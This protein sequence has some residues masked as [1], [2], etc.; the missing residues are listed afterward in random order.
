M[1]SN[2]K[3]IPLTIAISA[4]L[5]SPAVLPENT[6]WIPAAEAAQS[7]SQSG[8]SEQQQVN[9]FDNSQ[10]NYTD[11]EALAAFWG[12]T[13]VWEAKLKIGELVLKKNQLAVNSALKNA[14]PA[15]TEEK[16]STAFFNSQH[17][18]DD[19]VLLAHFWGQER[20]WDAKLKIGGLILDGQ[21]KAVTQA[22]EKAH[23]AQPA[24]TEEQQRVAF[25]NS[26]YTYDNAVLLAHFWGQERPWDAKLKIGD[27]LLDGKS[28]DIT[29][30]L[31]SAEPV[32]KED[33]HIG[34]FASSQ[35]TYDDA[36][37]LATFWGESSPWDAKL[38]MGELLLNN[39]NAAVQQAL[40]N[41]KTQ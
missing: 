22:L 34:A 13:S 12:T 33:Q 15:N 39:N 3:N 1:S 28:K 6:P 41:A 11:A 40:K 17:T 8:H 20:A 31:Q 2:K 25:F 37:R 18:Y 27:L 30:A 4:V 21:A 24:N 10:Y 9:A 38:K 26:Q 7:S 14:Q 19:A 35:Y 32:S 23:K 36:A 29:Q 16:Q 5:A